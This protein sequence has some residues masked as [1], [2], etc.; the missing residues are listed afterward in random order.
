MKSAKTKGP[1]GRG[2]CHSGVT[3]WG[4]GQEGGGELLTSV[5]T[6]LPMEKQLKLEGAGSSVLQRQYEA[7]GNPCFHSS[8]KRLT[9]LSVLSNSPGTIG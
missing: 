9:M 3:G 1:G 5:G 8:L 6:L 2:S 4:R 7:P